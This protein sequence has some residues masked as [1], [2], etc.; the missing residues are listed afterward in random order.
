MNQNSEN[1]KFYLY[2]TRDNF[3][4]NVRKYEQYLNQ[5]K[6]VDINKHRRTLSIQ[7]TVTPS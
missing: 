3:R 2:L 4:V 6:F 5:K 7:K 1:Y